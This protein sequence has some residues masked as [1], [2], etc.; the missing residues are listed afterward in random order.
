MGQSS[1][2][3]ALGADARLLVERVA[4]ADERVARVVRTLADRPANSADGEMDARADTRS[5]SAQTAG[6][7][8]R[9]LFIFNTLFWGASVLT[10][11]ATAWLNHNVQEKILDMSVTNT[12]GFLVCLIVSHV[13]LRGRTSDFRRLSAVS[14]A[15][16]ILATLICTAISNFTMVTPSTM[17]EADLWARAGRSGIWWANK[18]LGWLGLFLAVCYYYQSR[19]R[20]RRLA[21]VRAEA[22][23]AQMRALRYQINPHFLFNSLNAIASLI[24]EREF[25]TAERMVIDLSSF[26]RATLTLDPFQTTP[27]SEELALQT[28][29]LDIERTRFSDRLRV[30]VTLPEELRD[31]QTPS[32]ILQPLVENAV[33]HGLTPS[34][35]CVTIKLSAE[36]WGDRLV[37][38][39]ENDMPAHGAKQTS[40]AGVGLANVR[41]RLRALFE[42]AQSVEAGP[43]A[44][45][46]FAV[47]ISMPLRYTR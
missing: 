38:R 10:S 34:T 26:F 23:T 1:D 47:A 30:E 2:G 12:S 13:A 18:F 40:G 21:T 17:T 37:L 14:A 3:F 20:E 41:N 7:L 46:K 4:L 35:E 15:L 8:R 16:T 42:D 5:V 31:A 29:Y 24:S 36:K 39:V 9:D 6:R 33:K 11:W 45:G 19:D 27:L 25:S 44:A 32:L 43:T 22:F 28:L